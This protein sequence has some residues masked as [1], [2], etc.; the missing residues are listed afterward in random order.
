M[1]KALVHGAG[2]GHGKKVVDQFQGMTG[3]HRPDMKDILSQVV[4]YRFGPL[5]V[6]LVAGP[7]DVEQ[8]IHSLG[9]SAPQRRIHHRPAFGLAFLVKRPGGAG[10]GGTEIDDQSSLFKPGQN[11]AVT[12]HYRFDRR[13]GIDTE[14]DDVAVLSHPSWVFR[15]NGAAGHRLLDRFFVTVGHDGQVITDPPPPL[16][17]FR[18]PQSHAVKPY[19]WFLLTH[20]FLSF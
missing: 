5:E 11:S 7:H 13:S 12:S 10:N 20:H 16:N 17:Q 15:L 18:V 4:Q 9:W 8:S 14:H 6:G 19:A 2:S 1:A 3:P